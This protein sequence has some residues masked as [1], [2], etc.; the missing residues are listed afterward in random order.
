[1]AAPPTTSNKEKEV[2]CNAMRQQRDEERQACDE[3]AIKEGGWSREGRKE[4]DKGSELAIPCRQHLPSGASAA[5]SD[6]DVYREVRDR[7]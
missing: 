2:I 6:E 3:E 5:R 1:M 4:E 7:S